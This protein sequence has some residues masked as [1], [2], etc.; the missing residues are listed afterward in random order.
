MGSLLYN[1]LLFK[2]VMYGLLFKGAAGLIVYI[3]TGHIPQNW[4]YLAA[5]IICLFPFS[6]YILKNVGKA[7]PQ[8]PGWIFM[9]ISMLKMLI[10]PILIIL[11]FDKEHEDIE[12]L[13]MPLVISYL[14]LMAMDTKWKIKCL[15][16][17]R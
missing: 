5:I 14:M 11:F 7:W 6:T 17:R 15:L 3:E 16:N 10:L 2:E 4:F 1:A 13:V 8:S 12:A 9:V